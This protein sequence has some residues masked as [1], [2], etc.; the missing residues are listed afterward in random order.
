MT[1]FTTM[2]VSDVVYNIRSD[3]V[4]I[5]P[6]FANLIYPNLFMSK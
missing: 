6:Y 5:I 3:L 2:I 1:G 4:Y